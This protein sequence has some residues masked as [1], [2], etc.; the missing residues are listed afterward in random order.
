VPIIG[1]TYWSFRL[2]IGAG[3]LMLFLALAGVLL[4]RRVVLAGQDAHL[5]STTIRENILLARRSASEAELWDVLRAAGAEEW[6]RALP[7]GLDT[8]V[9]EDG[10]LLSGGQPRRVALARALLAEA[11]FLVLDE[12]TTHLDAETA[13]RVMADIASA[14]GERGVLVIA[15]GD[16]GLE[17]FEEVLELRG[18]RIAPRRCDP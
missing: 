10:G 8:F 5:F 16:A 4:M 2:M 13:R 9:G 14:A 6:V 1:V 15:H 18:G 7:D 12:P 11:R 3:M 17:C